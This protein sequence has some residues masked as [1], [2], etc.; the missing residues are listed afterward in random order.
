MSTG[1]RDKNSRQLGHHWICRYIWDKQFIEIL[2]IMWKTRK[3]DTLYI[4]QRFSK[5]FICI[6]PLCLYLR[7]ESDFSS[8][9]SIS[10]CCSLMS[11][12]RRLHS[13]SFTLLLRS[14]ANPSTSQLPFTKLWGNISGGEP[15]PLSTSTRLGVVSRR[16]FSAEPTAAHGSPNAITVSGLLSLTFSQTTGNA[17]PHDTAS[18]WFRGCCATPV[19]YTCQLTA[20]GWLAGGS[21]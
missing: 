18:N 3:R 17:E 13:R 20:G 6:I 4:A 12:C 21:Q 11:L 16:Q 15:H 14:S 9:S 8:R 1:P 2:K 10:G 7:S 19:H 5:F